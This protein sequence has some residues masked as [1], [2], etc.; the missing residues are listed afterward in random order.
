MWLILGPNVQEEKEKAEEKKLSQR[1]IVLTN[2]F[3]WFA[4]LKNTE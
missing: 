4:K 2:I 1:Y 3:S